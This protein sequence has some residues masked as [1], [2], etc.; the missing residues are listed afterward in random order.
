[1]FTVV[2]YVTPCILIANV[3]G[4]HVPEVRKSCINRR[5]NL[6]SVTCT[7]LRKVTINFRLICLSVRPLGT[8]RLPPDGFS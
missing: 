6:K 7:K 5:E 2:C 3:S 8:S 4:Y 1:M